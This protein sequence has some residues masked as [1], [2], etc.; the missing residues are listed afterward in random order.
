MTARQLSRNVWVEDDVRGANHSFIVTTEGLVL[1]DV[2]VDINDALAWREA[3]RAHGEPRYI[4]NSEFHLDHNMNNHVYECQVIASDV[5]RQIIV[6]ANND[7]WL[8]KQSKNLYRD[9]IDV[10]SPEDYQRGWPS[11][12]FTDQMT[13]RLGNHTFIIMFLPGHTPGE[14]A[15]YVPE[16]RLMFVADQVGTRGGA[17]LHDGLPEQWIAS[18]EHL[19]AFEIDTLLIGHGKVVTDKATIPGILDAQ[20][21]AIRARID[22][23]KKCKADGLSVH[24]TC[25]RVAEMFPGGNERMEYEGFRDRDP[26][27]AG[28]RRWVVH[29]YHVTGGNVSWD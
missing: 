22:A 2:P 11:I 10:P 8:R 26:G 21:E 1:F 20:Q 27:P 25:E 17:A 15:V 19:K 18:I 12:T 3:M 14:T 7:R 29:Q 5:T 4:V 28:Q 13:L 9:P 24:E 6:E 23:V 16:E